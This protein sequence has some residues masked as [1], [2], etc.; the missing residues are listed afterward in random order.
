MTD[1]PDLAALLADPARARDVPDSDLLGL[2]EETLA[3]QDQLQLVLRVLARR[4]LV[5]ATAPAPDATRM[6]RHVTQA[7]A[8]E[9]SGLPLATIRY[10]TRTGRV[11]SLKKGKCR[12]LLT[13]D[14]DRILE[15]CRARGLAL[16]TIPH[17][18]SRY[19]G[20][21]VAGGEALEADA[22][23]VRGSAGGRPEQARALGAGRAGRLDGG[24]LHPAPG[25]TGAAAA[26]KEGQVTRE[27][28]RQSSVEERP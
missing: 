10:L 3:R 6:A 12:L 25:P 22:G 17:A 18:S 16:R 9:R 19:R 1:R 28:T 5:H 15:Q 27:P 4:M 11:P 21:R 24:D 23:R 26:P 8:A 7:V 13:S 20:R 14:L 2:F